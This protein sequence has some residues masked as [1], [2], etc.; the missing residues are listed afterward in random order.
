MN[1]KTSTQNETDG[2]RLKSNVLYF[3]DESSISSALAQNLELFNW[4]VTLVSKTDFLFEKLNNDFYDILILDIMAPVPKQKNK[5]V[6]FEKKEMVEMED[7]MNTGIVIAKK[8][9]EME[10]YKDIPILFLS[11]RQRPDSINTFIKKGKK[12]DCLRK[13]ERSETI[14]EII[15]KLINES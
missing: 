1:K 11:A 13:P 15:E 7:G 4:N 9:W 12:C 14:N 3:D 2:K 10:K 5:Y 8:I 6:V